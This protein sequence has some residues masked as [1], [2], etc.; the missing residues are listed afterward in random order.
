M[1]WSWFYRRA[2]NI[3]K[4]C[5]IIETNFSGRF[6]RTFDDLIQLPGI[7]R[8]TAGAHYVYCLSATVSY[9]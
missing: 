8:S 9:S 3:Y 6:P 2:K 7:G 4:N 5:R 1:V